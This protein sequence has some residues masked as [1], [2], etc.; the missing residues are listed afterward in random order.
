M[1]SRWQRALSGRVLLKD[2][3]GRVGNYNNRSAA[4]SNKSKAILPHDVQIIN[5]NILLE[6]Y[7]G[8]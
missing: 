4:A 7:Y 1:F 2:R 8:K 6:H 3:K 5:A